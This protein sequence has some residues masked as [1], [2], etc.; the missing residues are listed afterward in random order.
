MASSFL[1]N[2]KKESEGVLIC[3]AGS[4]G[5][6]LG[7]KLFSKNHDVTLFGRRKLKNAG[8]T[9]VFI[10]NK[11]FRLPPS[12]F[13]MPKNAKY[14]FIFITSKLYDFDKIV[15][16]IDKNKVSGKKFIVIQNG[17]LEN[18]K[19]KKIIHQKIVP[20][21]VFGGF[22]IEKNKLTSTPTPV[23]W[24]TEYSEDGENISKFISS[25]GIK[26]MAEKNF[27][28]FRAE[29][30]IVNCCLNGLSAIEKKPFNKLFSNKEIKERIDNLFD[31]C[32]KVLSKQ[33]R[34]DSADK[35]KERLF[36]NWSKV[37]HYSSTYQD[38]MSKRKSEIDFFN[39]EIIKLGKAQG[40]NAEE[41]K[42][43]LME[44]KSLEK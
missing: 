1:A 4:I 19:Y 28:S 33:Y 30:M 38:L 5:I 15:K 37:N 29:K 9:Y 8:E 26:C 17:L 18:K 14:N 11:K 34:L 21:C 13:R 44:F 2:K 36:K 16:L 6:F 39:G 23:G 43:I 42:K 22:K 3:G 20:I 27:E 32:Y 35:I 41:N 7:A 25:C 24:L 31:E 40:I 12:I 10:N